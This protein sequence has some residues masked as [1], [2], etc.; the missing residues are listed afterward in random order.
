MKYKR[1]EE[2]YYIAKKYFE[3]FGNINIPVNYILDGYRIGDWISKQRSSYRKGLLSEEK[4]NKLTDLGMIWDGTI[5]RTSKRDEQF[6]KCFSLLEQYK[7]I[8]GNFNIPSNY[9]IKGVKLGKWASNLR[10]R[11]RGNSGRRVP[12]NHIK[13]L[14]EIGFNCDWYKDSLE[15]R[16]EQMFSLVVQYTKEHDISEIIESTRF[17]GE[18]IGSWIHIQRTN[19]KK[20]NLEKSRYD[21]LVSLGVDF[22]PASKRWDKA[23][24]LA[25]Q[26]YQEFHNLEIPNDY[27][28]EGF[29]LGAWISNQ[30]QIYNKSRNDMELTQEQITS[31]EQIGMVWKCNSAS[32]S[33]F[34][35][36]ALFYYLHSSFPDT[37]D[38]DKSNG[39][40]LDIY[41]PSAMTAIEY[42]GA[43]WHKN[44]LSQD[45]HKDE[46][47][48]NLGIK[49]IRIREYPLADTRFAV[50]YHRIN[51]F[52]NSTLGNLIS[53]ILKNEFNLYA[54]VDI[55]RDRYKIV[56]NFKKFSGKS[57]YSFYREA[58]KYFVENGNLL[59]PAN[60]VT[61]N[62]IKLGSWIHNQRQIF[63]GQNSGHLSQEEILLLEKIG[64]VWD[65]RELRWEQN[66]SV[67]KDY[68]KEFNNLL[69]SRSCEYH[70]IKL[71]KW[72]HA[73]RNAYK[74]KRNRKLSNHRITKLNNIGMVW[75][76]EKE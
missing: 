37:L 59:V 19:Y 28:V 60:H 16:W 63:K 48:Y 15:N 24:A 71:G 17:K 38:R 57:W 44:K 12:L 42:D 20:G 43:F 36:Q 62:N 30:R 35:E 3:M 74:G 25:K 46:L 29:N 33:S 26:Y 47:C 70:G 65:V 51:K 8:N 18:R 61:D 69:V 4:V 72:I 1:W 13:M 55:N 34:A 39:F 54:D 45:N 22:S 2:C 75:D 64:M 56:K 5:N 9:T 41:I 68:Y 76:I 14:N 40:E 6:L 50:C 52:D 58:K 31:L 49:L 27:V 73:Q 23:Y 10:N 66:Y 7:T 67:A 21:R 32:S 11:I 53:V